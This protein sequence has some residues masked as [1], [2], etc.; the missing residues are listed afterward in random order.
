M[1]RHFQTRTS[2]SQIGISGTSLVVQWFRL[3]RGSWFDP[4]SRELRSHRLQGVAKKKKKKKVGLS[5]LSL[6]RILRSIQEN[7]F[8]ET[9]IKLKK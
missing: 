1:E 6:G 2:S 4:W 3:C 7:Y 5:Q 9:L 8:L